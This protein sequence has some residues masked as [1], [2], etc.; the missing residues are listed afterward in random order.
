MQRRVSAKET[1]MS[2]P[3]G[4]GEV[5]AVFRSERQVEQV[6]FAT[7]GTVARFVAPGSLTR[8]RYGLFEWN[9]QPRSG[10]SDP[11]FHKTFSEAFYVMS[12]TVLLY[13]GVTWAPTSAGEF[14]YVPE[15]G[16]HAFRNDG[17][18]PVSMLILFAPGPPR[19]EYFRELAAIAAE[20]RTLT[21][22][23]WTDLFARHDQYRAE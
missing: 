13:N 23:E 12:G 18:V 9:M 3:A 11:H 19:E 17:D 2:Y 14:L 6:T 21:E 20:G 8:G 4:R 15:G 16:I 22:D 7:S 5:S 10:G 1:V